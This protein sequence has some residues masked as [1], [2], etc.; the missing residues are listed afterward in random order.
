VCFAGQYATEGRHR[1]RVW[2]ALSRYKR[3]RLQRKYR[4]Q[5]PR[6]WRATKAI[7]RA[8]KLVVLRRLAPFNLLDVWR[9][10]RCDLAQRTPRY[11]RCV[12]TLGL[13]ETGG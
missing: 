13:P 7:E 2:P 6:Q 10:K 11:D 5:P 3:A 12:W 9:G 4:R 8:S 1:D